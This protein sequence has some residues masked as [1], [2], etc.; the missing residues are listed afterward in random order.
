MKVGTTEALD[1]CGHREG[2]RRETNHDEHARD[3]VSK[4]LER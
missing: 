1:G 2:K 3:H 4:H